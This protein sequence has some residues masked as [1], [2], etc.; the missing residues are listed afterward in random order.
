MFT[1]PYSKYEQGIVCFPLLPSSTI[2]K[3]PDFVDAQVLGSA[4]YNK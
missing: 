1:V 4:D 2:I 3:Y